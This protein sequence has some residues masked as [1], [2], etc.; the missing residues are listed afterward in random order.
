MKKFFTTLMLMLIVSMSFAQPAPD[1]NMNF[2]YGNT[3]QVGF[4]TLGARGFNSNP[5]HFRGWGGM[6]N[7]AERGFEPVFNLNTPRLNQ[8]RVYI[9]E[10]PAFEQQFSRKRNEVVTFEIPDTAGT[11]LLRFY[12]VTETIDFLKVIKSTMEEIA[13]K[14]KLSKKENAAYVK[15]IKKAMPNTAYFW[16]DYAGFNNKIEPIIV[17][18]G[19]GSEPMIVLEGISYCRIKFKDLSSIIDPAFSGDENI[20]CEIQLPF[21][22]IDEVT[23]MIERL[24]FSVNMPRQAQFNVPQRR[25][26]IPRFR[27]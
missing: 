4:R 12:G 25:G 23:R 10:I 7:F 9:S 15:Q 16:D 20:K 26:F 24:N 18:N 5:V 22:G 8:V 19:K 3:P 17:Y 1:F 2:N 21:N 6:F 14:D 13:T 27:R 11:T